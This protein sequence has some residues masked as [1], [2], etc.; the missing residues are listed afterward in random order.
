MSKKKKKKTFYSLIFIKLYY[1]LNTKLKVMGVL[2][3][4]KKIQY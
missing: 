1:K 2:D 4:L 3:Y